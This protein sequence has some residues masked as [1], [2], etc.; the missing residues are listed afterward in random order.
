MSVSPSKHHQGAADRTATYARELGYTGIN[1]HQRR[2][3]GGEDVW[4]QIGKADLILGVSPAHAAYLAEFGADEDPKAAQRILAKTQTLKGLAHNTMWTMPLD[5]MARLFN[6]L[7]RRG[8]ATKDPY[9]QP[10]NAQGEKKFR[11]MLDDVVKDSKL[12]VARLT[13]K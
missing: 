4:A 6:Q 1:G 12:A 2:A 7:Y 8:L 3:V 9:F 10:K 5:G 11:A 13:K